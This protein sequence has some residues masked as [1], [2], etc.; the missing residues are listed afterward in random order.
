M[1]GISSKA[2]GSLIN[3]IKY[4]GKEE[5]RQEFSDGS[6]LEWMD[7]GARMY[8]A[9]IGRWHV[10][11]PLGLLFSN[12]SPYTYTYDNPI[13][14][15][16]PN[17]MANAGARNRDEEGGNDKNE[18]KN[19]DEFRCICE[20][21]NLNTHTDDGEY[22]ITHDKNG[23]EIKRKVSD[24]GDKEGIDFN[25]YLDGD[26]ANK[27]EIVDIE[28]GKSQLMSSSKNIINYAKRDASVGWDRLYGEYLTGLGP[29]KS[30]ITFPNTMIVEMLQMFTFQRAFKAFIKS[31]ET[32]F[33][34]TPLFFPITPGTNMTDQFIGK[35]TFSFYE[36]GKKI[37]VVGID[38]KSRSS[39]S[40]IFKSESNNVPR[41]S[42]KI[43]ER[44]TTHQ[45]YIFSLPIKVKD[46]FK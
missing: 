9:Q 23:N 11:D 2:A 31:G 30:I 45:T 17:G 35:A 43:I 46:V 26:K 3:H 5:Q 20:G 37:V 4:N 13:N 15:I 28:S 38:S 8:D 7:Y 24:L 32:K 40:L 25:H 39:E 44:S 14:F 10:L 34:S 21:T 33:S 42:G 1:A 41:Q 16:D 18:W 19:P 22:E 6:G 12:W 27:T 29:E 36:V